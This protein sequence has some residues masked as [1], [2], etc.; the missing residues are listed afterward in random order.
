MDF[1]NDNIIHVKDG[2]VE[3]IQF[4]RLLEYKDKLVHAY[5]LKPLDLKNKSQEDINYIKI[6]KSLGLDNKNV[7]QPIQTHTNNVDIAKEESKSSD[8]QD[9]DGLI[10]SLKNKVLSAVFADCNSLLL[11][12]PVKN[13]IGNIHSG[14]RGTVGRIGEVAINKMV[15]TYGCSP[16]DIICCIGPSI[17]QCHF[18]VEDDVR[19]LFFD[20]FQ[21][22]SIIKIGEMKDGKQK[23]YIDSIKAITGML[24]E[25]GLHPDNIID[26]GICTLCNKDYFHSYR[27]AKGDAG[28]NASIMC[29]I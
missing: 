7:I 2:D 22:E 15:D 8:F 13:V 25:C 23:Y 4:K 27:D 28:R 18:E 10:T 26:C 14:W 6:C 17:R 16:S 24:I 21:D 20:A 5:T 1:S 19:S 29:L 3:Y 12:D 11:Y 9:I